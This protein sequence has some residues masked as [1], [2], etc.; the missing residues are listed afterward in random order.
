LKGIP[1]VPPLIAN[2]DRTANNLR[3]DFF[4]KLPGFG[5][6]RIPFSINLLKGLLIFL[7]IPLGLF[8][9]L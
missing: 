6:N 1:T 8:L 5:F 9:S 3:L 7:P 4:W 2:E